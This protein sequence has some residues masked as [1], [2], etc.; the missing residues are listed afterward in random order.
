M[1]GAGLLSALKS[2]ALS[3]GFCEASGCDWESAK[4]EYS[5]HASRYEEWLARGF[6][7]E[8]QYLARGLDRRKNPE[9]VFPGLK[10][11]F[12]VLLPYRQSPLGHSD[13]SKGP[14]YARYLD[15]TDYHERIPSKLE[16]VLE[17]VRAMPEHSA[18]KWK[19]CV[20]TSAVLERTWGALTGLGWIGKNTLLIHPKWGSRFFIGVAYLNLPL[21][22]PMAPIP[23]YCGHCTRCLEGC[24]T[25][26]ITEPHW[27]DSRQCIS[28]WTLEKRGELDLTPD[29][30][31][32]MGT[33]VAGCD[34][35]QD[36]CPFNHKPEKNLPDPECGVG[37]DFSLTWEQLEG[38]SE[39]RYQ[40]RVKASALS[41]V[42]PVMARRNL[43]LAR[44][45]SGA[46]VRA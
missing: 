8:M 15:G 26:A 34:I 45:N 22:T 1:A 42:K 13:P 17:Q 4:S 20:D 41:R 7:G 6:A 12:C 29:Q 38:E 35:C 23:D 33:W 5:R 16:S 2:E 3:Q 30:K 11:I 28:Y 18:L 21:E 40:E 44:A 14:R 36:V 9:L 46:P 24:P 27:L 19:I 43:A 31:Q 10:S 39:S 32:S 25:G 37:A